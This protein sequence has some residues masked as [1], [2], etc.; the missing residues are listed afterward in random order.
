MN[1]YYDASYVQQYILSHGNMAA[2]KALVYIQFYE[3]IFLYNTFLRNA[4]NSTNNPQIYQN[5]TFLMNSMRNQK[6]SGPFGQIFLDGNN[7]RLGAFR[8][9]VILTEKNG[10]IGFINIT[11]SGT[12]GIGVKSFEKKCTTLTADLINPNM[13]YVKTLPPDIPSCGFHGELCDQKGTIIIVVAVMGAVSIAITIFLCARKMKSGESASMPWAI[14]SATV[15]FIDESFKGSTE[16]QSISIHSLKENP[17]PQINGSK[18]D[19]NE[20]KHQKRLFGAVDQLEV[21]IEVFQLREKLVFDKT[22]M[23]ML[24]KIKNTVHDNTNIFAGVSMDMSH[25]FFLMWK[26][27]VRGTLGDVIL[28]N[29]EGDRTAM[30]GQNFTGAYVR[31]IIKGLDFLH[32]SPIKYHGGLTINNCLID[33]HWIVKLSGFGINRLLYKW[34]ISGMVSSRDGGPII[35]DSELHYFAPNLRTKIAKAA[36]LNK[37]SEIDITVEEGQASD[38]FS[39]GIVLYE[40][41][42]KKKAHEFPESTVIRPVYDEGMEGLEDIEIGIL[43]EAALPLLPTY[44]TIPEGTEVHPDLISLM[45][46]CFHGVWQNRPDANMVRKITDAT[47]KMPGS[48]VDQM[49]KNMEQYNNNLENLVKQRTGQ[50]EEAQKKSEEILTE[51]LPKTVADELKLGRTVPP[52]NYKMATVMYS[53]IVGFTS[54]CS[55]SQPMEVVTLLSG[56]FQAFDS[57]IGQHQAYKVETIGD[58]YMVASGVPEKIEKK[59]VKEIA[60]IALKQR[61]FL[62]GYTIPHR[63]GQHLHC[64]WGFNTGPVFT[65]VVGITAPRYC[66]F[67]K[68]VTIAAK[69]E[70]SGIQDKIQMTVYSQKILADC[71]PEF[72]YTKRDKQ[73]SVNGFGTYLTY[74]L[75]SYEELL[76]SVRDLTAN[77]NTINNNDS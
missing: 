51:L 67:G 25:E 2:D 58:A 32:S 71:F 75:E 9:S 17:I 52:K 6:I 68:T 54:L 23:Q 16:F 50:L 46:K 30:I 21:V 14:A 8:T 18:L 72:Q 44:P 74:W 45:H 73:I 49:I 19:I 27:C 59:H 4:Y 77:N 33:S 69:M 55:E 26:H 41:L 24:F 43:N 20:V 22:D 47:L 70:N 66:V 62:F 3:S 11:I 56:L 48:L 10:S 64:R 76:G 28:G 15:R 36:S 29:K 31:D 65:G 63:P 34:K 1:D 39:F 53:D 60:M 40:I 5:S 61:D 12:C 37:M 13:D 38:I 35:P 42:F 57:I 7:Q